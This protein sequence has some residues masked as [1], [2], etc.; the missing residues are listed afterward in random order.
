MLRW[1]SQEEHV[2]SCDSYFS[3]SLVPRV[4]LTRV[5]STIFQQLVLHF[6]QILCS[7][8]GGWSN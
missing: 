1:K 7:S 4:L 3:K 6:V 2:L 8:L 5:Q